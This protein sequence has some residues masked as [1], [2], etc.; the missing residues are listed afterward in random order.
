[1]NMKQRL[2]INIYKVNTEINKIIYSYHIFIYAVIIL[3]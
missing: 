1:M 2:R 3:Q